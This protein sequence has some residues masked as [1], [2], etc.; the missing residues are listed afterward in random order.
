MTEL[1]N[2]N[3]SDDNQPTNRNINDELDI[4]QL[5]NI[6]TS[7]AKSS[8]IYLVNLLIS[9][10]LYIKRSLIIIVPVSI[11]FFIILC[12]PIFLDKDPTNKI[13]YKASILVEPQYQSNK[14]LY[15][16][17]DQITTY[18][19]LK[20]YQS[21]ADLLVIDL[22]TAEKID[23]IEINPEISNQ[24]Y[25]S[26]INVTKDIKNPLSF[27]QFSAN[28]AKHNYSRHLITIYS[29]DRDI[30]SKLEPGLLAL[31]NTNNLLEIKKQTIVNSLAEIDN[32]EN[33][34]SRDIDILLED[35]SKLQTIPNNGGVFHPRR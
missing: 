16:K 8:I 32:L 35:N 6:F 17:I 34:V 30:F 2:K 22:N 7:W 15:S 19:E 4:L 9:L 13:N 20:D 25:I 24:E 12:T 5:L 1:N 23:K 29:K 31:C 3:R 10:I 28:T 26:Y 21:I 33:K 18:I 27:E 11:L 14:L